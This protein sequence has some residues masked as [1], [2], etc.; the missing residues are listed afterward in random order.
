MLKKI[1]I[2]VIALIALSG[3][4]F[5][6]MELFISDSCSHCNEL[7]QEITARELDQKFEIQ[8]YEI[9]NNTEN[10]DY[11]IYK[12]QE[13]G[14]QN[15]QVPLLIDGGIYKE[16]T[17]AILEYLQNKEPVEDEPGSSNGLSG[18]D[19]E[20]LNELIKAQVKETFAEADQPVEQETAKTN[21]DSQK[22]KIL[23]LIVI[24]FGLTL[25]GAIIWRARAAARPPKAAERRLTGANKKKPYS[26]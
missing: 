6:E 26:N 18:N 1:S 25:F 7:Q 8:T 17:S 14:Y 21:D 20:K 19:S 9:Y 23:G 12:A 4:A 5:A 11:Y 10:R 24:I 22:T 13:L 2:T 15:A 3:T 16:G